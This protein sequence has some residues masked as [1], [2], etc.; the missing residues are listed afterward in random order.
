MSPSW[1]LAPQWPAPS[2][3]RAACTL[4]SGG[5]SVAPYDTLNLASHVGD[6]PDAVASNRDIVC[7][8]LQLPCEPLWLTQVHGNAV[9]DA[10]TL[11]AGEARNAPSADA[12]FT[13]RAGQVLSVLV[14]DCLPVLMARR[15]GLAV[16]VAHA[17]WRGLA[18]GVLEATAT[19]LGA[20]SAELVVWLGPAIGAEHFE[21]GEEVRRR[22]CNDDQGS[23]AAFVRNER[24]RWQCDLNWLARRQLERLNVRCVHGGNHCTFSEAQSFYSYRRDGVTGRIAALIWIEAASTP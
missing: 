15:D 24:N 10:D 14:A 3:V 21:V 22:F 13:C 9:V 5:V 1:L 12:A 6:R 23:A 7:A 2:S 4:R 17:G 19:A 20:P 16:A 18:S 8:G 11:S